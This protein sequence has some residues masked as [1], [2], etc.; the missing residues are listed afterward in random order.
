VG[1]DAA[2]GLAVLVMALVNF[3]V[4]LSMESRQPEWLRTFTDVFAGR[5]AATFVTL[6]GMGVVLLG[7]R[8]VLLRR[9][10]FLGILGYGW[11]ELWP[12]DILHFYAFYLTCGA[13]CLR[14]SARWVLALAPLATLGFWVLFQVF[15]YGAGWD[16]ETL[17]YVDFWEPQGQLRQLLFNGLHPLL[18]WLSFLFLGMGLAKLDLPQQ[19][20]SRHSMLWAAAALLGAEALSWYAS[21]LSDDREAWAHLSD[22]FRAPDAIWGTSPLP[23]GPLYVLSA[24]GSAVLCIG[25]CLELARLKRSRTLLQPVIAVGQLA[26]TSYV[27]HIFF[28]YFLVMPVVAELLTSADQP[29]DLELWLTWG[30]T[31]AFGVLALAGAALWRRYYRR[32]PLEGVMRRL[33]D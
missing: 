10:L 30:A 25:A 23:P 9:A 13:L 8:R 14:L 18:P 28:L 15:D 1:L 7:E 33:T 31:I 22:W 26:L 19:R 2:R 20:I 24:A 16:W 5:A 12:G 17:D 21:S 6:A 29:G 4:V 11:Y 27:A 32:G 3:D